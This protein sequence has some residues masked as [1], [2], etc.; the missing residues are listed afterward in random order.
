MDVCL[1]AL[2]RDHLKCVG[3]KGI[4][5]LLDCDLFAEFAKPLG[6]LGASNDGI[7][8][9]PQL[10]HPLHHRPEEAVHLL[11]TCAGLEEVEHENAGRKGALHFLLQLQ[12]RDAPQP[13]DEFGS[14]D[15]NG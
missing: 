13:F 7:Q 10:V 6:L 9:A 4:L 1:M 8:S 14:V 3:G 11:F 12:I 5:K 15:L 2:R